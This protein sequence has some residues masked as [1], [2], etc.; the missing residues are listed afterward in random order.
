MLWVEDVGCG[1]IIDDNSVLEISSDLGQILDV[2]SLVVVAT[3]SEK[4]VVYDLVDI[5]LVKE[6]VAVLIQ[7]VSYR[8]ATTRQS[9]STYLRDRRRENNNL[10]KL[11]DSPHKLVHAWALDNI[12]IV[13][14][15][16]NF[17]GYRKISLV[18]NLE[19]SV[20]WQINQQRW[21]NNLP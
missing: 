15:S 2:V 3:L 16:F 6:R 11:A 13:V 20:S 14:V 17:N 12:D 18:Q 21:C 1:R 10:I 4:P 19:F 8:L 5:Q 9:E 7:G